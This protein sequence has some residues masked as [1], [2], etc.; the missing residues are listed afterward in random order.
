MGSGW[1]VEDP[2]LF[3]RITHLASEEILRI[4]FINALIMEEFHVR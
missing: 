2:D 4:D 1:F 3:T